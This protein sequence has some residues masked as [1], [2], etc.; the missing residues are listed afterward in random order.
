MDIIAGV[1]VAIVLFCI[2]GKLIALPFHI[3]W[4]LITNSIIGA[5]ILWGINLFGVGIKITF[6]KALVAGI[7]GIPGVVLI[8]IAHALGY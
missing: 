3:L 6:L 2:L 1:A 4:K 7:F 8:L 5:I